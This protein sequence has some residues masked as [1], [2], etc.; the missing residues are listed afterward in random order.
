MRGSLYLQLNVDGNLP[1]LVCVIRTRILPAAGTAV[2]VAIL[3]HVAGRVN[4]A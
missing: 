3:G 2:T 1:S 4:L